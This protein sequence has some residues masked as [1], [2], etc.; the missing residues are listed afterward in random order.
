MAPSVP[1]GSHTEAVVLVVDDD[2]DV[3]AMLGYALRQ[4]GLQPNEA[5]SGEEALHILKQREP[6]VVLL[7]VLMPGLDGLET[8]ERIRQ[9]SMVPVI[10][11]TALGRQDDVVAGLKAGADDYCAKPVNLSELDARIRVQ[12]RRREMQ[13]RRGPG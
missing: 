1:D 5:S 10:M 7:D 13:W 8:C 4:H 3:R 2:P 11:L 12:L 6:N 9:F